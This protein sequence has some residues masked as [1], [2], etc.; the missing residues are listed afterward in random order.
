MRSKQ[1]GD[2]PVSRRIQ[3]YGRS[4]KDDSRILR[5]DIDGF[6]YRNREIRRDDFEKMRHIEFRMIV[7]H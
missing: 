7:Q 6:I 4:V 2:Q 3:E 1:I 5:T